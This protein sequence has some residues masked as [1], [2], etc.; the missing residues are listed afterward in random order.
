MW[1]SR[2]R[3]CFSS[4]PEA[5]GMSNAA[6]RSMYLSSGERVPRGDAQPRAAVPH[7]HPPVSSLSLQ[8]PIP[9]SPHYPTHMPGEDELIEG[10][11]EKLARLRARGIDPYPPRVDRTHSAADALA[12]FDRLGAV[13]RRGRRAGGRRRRPHRRAA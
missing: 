2:P 4:R 12:A 11:R 13:R 7:L 1:H 3:L 6:T 9:P 10:R 5:P 8:L